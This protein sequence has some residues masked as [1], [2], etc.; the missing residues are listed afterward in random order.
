MNAETLDNSYWKD[1]PSNIRRA[2]TMIGFTQQIWDE[3]KEW[4]LVFGKFWKDISEHELNLLNFLGYSETN[5][6]VKQSLSLV[7]QDKTDFIPPSL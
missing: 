6:K 5:W 1:L 4:P 7:A 2:A 3:K